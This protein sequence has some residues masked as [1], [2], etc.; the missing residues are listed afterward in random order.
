MRCIAHR[1]FAGEFA[2]NTVGAVS[3]AA[4]HADWVEVDVRQCATGEVVVIHDESVDRVTNATGKVGELAQS[5]LARLNV[6]DSGEGVPTLGEVLEAIPESVGI[7][8]ELKES[9]LATAVVD[10]LAGHDGGVLVSSFDAGAL[11]EVTVLA[12]YPRALL[13]ESDPKERIARAA[14]LDCTAI[15]PHWDLCDERFV[16]RAHDAN[17]TVNAWTIRD[18]VGAVAARNAG[19]DGYISDYRQFCEE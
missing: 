6:L 11:A 1:G 15:H 16:A 13:V 10:V 12:D 17:L 3:A 2:E 18:S 5:E 19:V 14:E 7:N 9:G 4:E 8:V